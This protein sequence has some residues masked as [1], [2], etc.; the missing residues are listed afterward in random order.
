MR[1][2]PASALAG[3]VSE[4]NSNSSNNFL[5]SGSEDIWK[6]VIV[7]EEYLKGIDIKYLREGILWNTISLLRYAEDLLEVMD[8]G[9]RVDVVFE[10]FEKAF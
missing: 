10:E 6:T 2:R 8:K 9:G 4:F 7:W 1:S 5:K 3:N